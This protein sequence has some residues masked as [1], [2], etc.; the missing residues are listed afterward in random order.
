MVYEVIGWIN[1]NVCKVFFK[2][3]YYYKFNDEGIN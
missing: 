1:R 3:Y 2:E